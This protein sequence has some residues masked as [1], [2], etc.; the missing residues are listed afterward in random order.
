MDDRYADILNMPHP[1]S[2]V[3]PRMGA[4]ERAAQFA[5]FAA[6]TGYEDAIAEGARLTEESKELGE[7][8]LSDLNEKITL[9]QGR[10]GEHPPVTVTYFLPD[11]KKA[12][13]RYVTV[14][15]RIKKLRITERELLLSEGAPISLDAVAQLESPL[16]SCL[17]A[18]E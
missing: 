4:L 12:G 17:E 14:S 6:L 10:L 16:F 15:G 8:A 9:L 3:H 5:P 1:V 11:E 7:E 18:E 13:G 2:P